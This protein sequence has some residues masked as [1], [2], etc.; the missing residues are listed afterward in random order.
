MYLGYFPQRMVLI[1]CLLKISNFLLNLSIEC[2]PS[3]GTAFLVPLSVCHPDLLCSTLYI[4]E[5]VAGCVK[6]VFFFLNLPTH[7]PCRM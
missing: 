4:I 2:K 7:D 3:L 6:L 5:I 1:K